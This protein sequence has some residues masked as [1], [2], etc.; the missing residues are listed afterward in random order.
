MTP[1]GA[2]GFEPVRSVRLYERIVEQVEET[3]ARG[4]LRPGQRLPS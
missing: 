3:I 2:R 1:T 4:E